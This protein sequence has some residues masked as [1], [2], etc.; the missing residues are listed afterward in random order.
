MR[1]GMR[2]ARLLTAAATRSA[3]T[4]SWGLAPPGGV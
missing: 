1:G 3:F 2:P 4:T